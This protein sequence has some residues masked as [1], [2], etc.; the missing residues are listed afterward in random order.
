[1]VWAPLILIIAVALLVVVFYNTLV[2]KKNQVDNAFASIDVMLKKRCDLIPNL[3]AT[4][5]EYMQFEQQTLTNIAGLRARAVSG[6][7]SP[8]ARVD[9]ENQLSRELG[10]LM[11]AVEAY[12]DLKANQNFLQLQGSLNEVEEQIS[13]ARRFYNSAVT[14][15]NN[16]VEMFPT[17]IFAN[18]MSY[19]KR[20]WFEATET[21]RRNV[22]VRDLFNQ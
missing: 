8:E 7:L 21:E 10:N 13:A 17:N 4:A 11:V 14:D 9:V 6:R 20:P 12:P 15:Y 16:A 22:N 19:R 1:M 2:G 18:M 3:V 5:K